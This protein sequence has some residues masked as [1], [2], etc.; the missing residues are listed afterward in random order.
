MEVNPYTHTFGIASSIYKTY[1]EVMTHRTIINFWPDLESFAADMVVQPLT[2]AG[3][4]NRDSI[5]AKYWPDLVATARKR[6]FRGVTL[7]KLNAHIARKAA[8]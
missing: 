1:V 3:W 7:E 2:A 4:R 8:A 6:G 5:P